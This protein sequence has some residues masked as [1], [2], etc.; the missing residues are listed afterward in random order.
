MKKLEIM[1]LRVTNVKVKPY[2]LL[3]FI[4]V[5]S[6]GQSYGI[7]R[8]RVRQIE[9][10]AI[11]KLMHPVRSRKLESFLDDFQQNLGDERRRE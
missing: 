10:K 7:T 11:R 6:I 2:L 8:E 9:A 5:V 1:M 3:L 4:I